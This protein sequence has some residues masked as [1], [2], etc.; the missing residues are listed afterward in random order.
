M[1]IAE[2][3]AAVLFDLSD[4]DSETLSP[5]EAEAIGEAMMDAADIIVETLGLTVVSV[6]DE[7]GLVH[8]T[9]PLVDD[10]D[11]DEDDAAE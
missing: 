2:E 10:E 4:D 9:I 6:D 8:L 1:A 11:E 7:A 3:I 5:E